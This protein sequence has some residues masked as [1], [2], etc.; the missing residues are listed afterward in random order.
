MATS[1]RTI[2]DPETVVADTV[3]RLRQAFDRGATK[4]LAWRIRQLRAVKQLL[5]ERGDE[6]ERALATDLG[7]SGTEAQI[8]EIGLLISE[9]DHTLKHLKRWVKPRRVAVPLTLAPASASVVAEPVGVVLVIGPWNYPVQL[10][11]GPMIGALAA[12]NAVLLKPSEL[13]PATSAALARLLPE[14]LDDRAVAVVEGDAEV[15]TALLAERFD[16]VFY[17]GGAPVGRVVARAAAEHL[18]PITLELGGKSPV[19]IDDTVDLADAARRIMWGKLMNAGQTCV[20]PDYVLATKSVADRLVP[21]LRDAVAHLYGADPAGNADY[22][23][24]ISDR[25]FGRVSGLLDGLEPVI[26]GVVDASQRYIAPTVVNGVDASAAIMQEEIFGPI[27]PILH[28]SGLEQAIAHIR[29]GEKPLALYVFSDDAT[30]RRRFTRDTSSGA[31][32]FGVPAAHLM[33]PGLPFGGVGAS[34]MG[35]YHGRHSFDTFSHAKAVFSKPLSPDTLS[36]V[37]PPFTEARDRIVR[38]LSRTGRA[39]DAR[40]GGPRR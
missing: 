7:K 8:T 35:A 27:L 20:A 13:A 37:Y 14:Y 10:S 23:R 12:G 36:L 24:I 2:Q 28:V 22:G 18:T 32:A 31:L 6:L 29:A 40:L 4:P 9:L 30:T 38:L 15:A 1:T 34:G 33:V 25:H 39:G 26:G 17:T 21:Y 11:L 16:H 19:Y 5:L 3:A